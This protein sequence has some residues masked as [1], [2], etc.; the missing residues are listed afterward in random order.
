[1][2]RQICFFFS[3]QADLFSAYT[4]AK[5]LLLLVSAQLSGKMVVGATA[6]PDSCG[7]GP[8][9]AGLQVTHLSMTMSARQEWYAASASKPH[10]SSSP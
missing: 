6:R 10:A 3:S 4:S 1:M 9:L 7:A 5:Q 2:S 8:W